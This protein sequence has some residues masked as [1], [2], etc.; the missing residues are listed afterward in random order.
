MSVA[1]EIRN[2]VNNV[3]YSG[4]EP[5][6]NYSNLCLDYFETEPDMKLNY[7]ILRLGSHYFDINLLCKF[8]NLDVL[9]LGTALL[10]QDVYFLDRRGHLIP[11]MAK[12]ICDMISSSRYFYGQ[13]TSTK[14]WIL[15]PI[16]DYCP[17]LKS[18]FLQQIYN[19][20]YW[21]RNINTLPFEQLMD[22]VVS[23]KLPFRWLRY[24][25]NFK[26]L[27]N[28]LTGLTSSTLEA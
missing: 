15:D 14:Q 13:D 25:D 11:S 5:E 21:N 1:V 20:E 19:V 17:N 27:T 9:T 23:G 2:A 8:H 28:T 22:D 16:L 6:G 7:I 4:E 24:I 26:E 18:K 3:L 12:E 10:T